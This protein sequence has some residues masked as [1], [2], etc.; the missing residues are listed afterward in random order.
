M[1]L[2][3]NSKKLC[4]SSKK[5]NEVCIHCNTLNNICLVFIIF[6]FRIACTLLMLL[7]GYTCY[8]LSNIVRLFKYL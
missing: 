6:E 1:L 4:N 2:T 7:K 8:P 3:G 5:N